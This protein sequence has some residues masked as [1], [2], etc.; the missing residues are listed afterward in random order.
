MRVLFATIFLL[1]SAVASY[2]QSYV[3]KP[4][5][6]VSV[7]VLEDTSLNRS[8][9]VLPDG[10]VTFP[11]VGTL[12]A[13]G[14]T[15]SSFEAALRTALAPN[16]A[17]EPTVFVSINTL[18]Q[19]TGTDTITVYVLGQVNSPGPKTIEKG[20]T[21]L[22]ALSATG[23]LSPFAA[24]KRIQLRRVDPATQQENVFIF[25]LRAIDRG[26]R[27]SGTSA[28]QDGDVILVPERRLFE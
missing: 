19:G 2:A 24:T 18:S 21:F 14:R 7:E 26:A 28:L 8:V 22:Q 4:G 25:D 23:G 20:L 10:T 6:V 1:L 16:F 17:A 27:I 9:L 12:Q 3:L 15:I 13:G 11:F 5:D